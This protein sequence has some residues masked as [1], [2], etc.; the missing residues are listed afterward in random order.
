[1]DGVWQF[2]RAEIDPDQKSTDWARWLDRDVYELY[3][4]RMM[5]LS[6]EYAILKLRINM[7]VETSHG[8]IASHLV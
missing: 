6:V 3:Q 7:I 2:L 5:I 1:M 4:E 8:E